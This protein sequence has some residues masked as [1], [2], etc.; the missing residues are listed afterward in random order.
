MGRLFERIFIILVTISLLL[1]AAS[2]A[3]RGVSQLAAHLR[4]AASPVMQSVLTTTLIGCFGVGLVVR[5]GSWLQDSRRKR[6]GH[7]PD[8]DR[9]IRCG[10]RRPIDEP[11]NA[12]PRARVQEDHDPAL[13]FDLEP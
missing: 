9:Q 5:F 1:W 11:Q 2:A 4:V 8:R 13:N 12:R 7:R 6:S 3:F 10:V